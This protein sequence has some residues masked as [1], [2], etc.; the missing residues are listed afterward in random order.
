VNPDAPK[1]GTLRLG[2][3]ATT[4][5]TFNPFVVR[6]NPAPGLA[7][8]YQTL[9]EGSLDE[10]S[11]EYGL[12]AEKVEIAADRMW[13]VYHLRPEARFHD[14]SQITPE[15]VIWSF[16]ILREKGR[17]HFR[18][19]YGDVTSVEKVGERGVKFSFKSNDNRELPQILGQMPVLSKKYWAAR[20]F[21]KTT[22]EPPVGSGPY[23]IE[24][25]DPGRSITFKR[26]EDWWGKGLPVNKGR[27]NFDLIVYDLYR[28]QTVLLEAFKAGRFDF[29]Q[30]NSSKEWATAYDIPAVRQGLVKKEEIKHELPTGMQGFGFNTRRDLF[31]DPRVRHALSYAFD[32][33]WSNQHLFYGAYTRT[34]SYF[35]NSELAATGLP[36][37]EE[38]KI[39]EPYRGRV[40]EEVFTKEYQPPTYDGSGNI[41]EGLRA[42]LGLLRQA[43]WSVKSNRLVEEKTGRPFEFEILLAS[44]QFE[45]IVLPFAENLKRLGITARVRTVDSAQYQR[46]MD[47]FDFDMT[48]VL[49]PQS[50]SPG[51]EQRD[52]WNSQRASEEGSRNLLGVR[53]P[54]VD[55]LIEKLIVAP[56]RDSLI[57]HTKALD[58]VLLYGHYV[59]PNWHIQS[60]RVAYWDKFKHP[61]VT[62]KYG[63]ALNAWWLDRP[64]EQVVEARKREVVEE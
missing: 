57:A 30:E 13:V 61:A 34:K 37:G 11:S 14:G 15:D 45:R 42:A 19:Y 20:E 27:F 38:L 60:F 5:D 39:L 31:Q 9:M 41:R 17:P 22:L 52:F 50:L 43:G 63:L 62:P 6:G 26:V 2:V 8:L 46:R 56:D 64:S 55:E 44:A 3:Y 49:F 18:G 33:A 48:V 54:V 1:G 16:D 21:E 29:R 12:I 59:I 40:P 28:D 10:P 23:R 47:V 32:F 7:D 53:D 51:N 35:S 24:S 58:R 4:F 36:E 25:F